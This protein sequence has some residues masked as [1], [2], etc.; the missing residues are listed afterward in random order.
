[1]TAAVF[2]LRQGRAILFLLIAAAAAGLLVARRL[3]KAVYPEVEFY[4]EQVVATLPGAPAATMIAGVTRP[5]EE[6]LAAIPGVE[7]IRS[8]TI[9][10]ATQ[11]SLFF[12]HG[13]DMPRVQAL[14]VARMAEIRGDLPPDVQ[15]VASRVTTS[16][17][18]ILSFNVEGPLPPER[19]YEL[20][21]YTLVPALSGLPHVGTI[22]VQ[23]SDIPEVQVLLDPERLSASQLTVGDVA[24]ALKSTNVVQAVA[25]ITDAHELKLGIVTGEVTTTAELSEAVVGGT[26]QQPIRVRDLGRVLDGV[27][28]RTR[29]I[30]V[31]G[32]PGVILN[33]SRRVGGDIFKVDR[34][35]RQRLAELEPSLPTG[36]R[37]VPVYEQA[38]FVTEGVNGVR[39][40]VL[41]GALF[42]VAVLALF[43][44]DLRATSIAAMSLP[45]ALGASLLVLGALGQSLNLMT[46]GGLAVAVGLVIDDAVVVIEAVHKNLEAGLAPRLAAERGTSELFWPVVGT[47]ATT[48][49][50]FL[51]LGLQ[52]GVSGAFFTAFSLA[53]AS[54]VLISLPVALLAMPAVAARFLRPLRKPSRGGRL[55]QRYVHALDRVLDHPWIP[56]GAAA[57]LLVLGTL[58]F[59]RVPT[60]FLP[61]AD[62]G[63]YVID[64]FPPVGA[65]L[66]EAD[67]L[68]SRIEGVVA[69]T[70]EV[71]AFARRLGA[72]LGPPTA[73]LASSGDISVRLATERERAIHEVLDEQRRELAVVVPGVRVEFI[74]VLADMLGDL[75]GAPEP[76]EVKIFGPDPEVLRRLAADA[77]ARIESVPGLVDFFNGDEG[78][79]PER[80]LRVDPIAAGSHGLTVEDVAVQLA[81]ANLGQVAT[82]LRRPDHLE[83]VRVR[84]D[85]NLRWGEGSEAVEGTP[86][87]SADAGVVPV[88]SVGRW[89]DSCP[90]ATQ[91]RDDHQ[92]IVHLTARLSG[93]SLG[94]AAKEVHARLRDWKLPAGYR[95]QL[96]GLLQPQKESFDRML[97][98][99]SVA[100]LAVTA[101]LL[102]QLR[103]VRRALAVLAAMPLAL[104]AGLITLWLTGTTL[105]VASMMGAVVLVG[106]VVKN[107]I[108]LLDH[109]LTAEERGVPSRDALLE[110]ASARLRPILMTTVATV[111]ALLPL[112]FGWSA[113]AALHRPLAMIVVGGLAFSTAA[114]LFVVPVLAGTRA[115]Q[116]KAPT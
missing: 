42:A 17:F 85:V 79:S 91:L 25:R 40:A 106:L 9:R 1:M 83:D 47:T 44:R 60:D 31:D 3:P 23:S 19:L 45:L 109:A 59:S 38:V 110:A 14:V 55:T 116:K 15:L 13:T 16:D 96:A 64:Y 90:P 75:E 72:E 115:R 76:I 57:A 74:Q 58:A 18:P 26:A 49:V 71:T 66:E 36:V 11:V 61:E 114:T 97:L 78:C 51:P 101:V 99:L 98:V 2:A 29:I 103:S 43:L 94:A 89:E 62:E 21:S 113:G 69:T 84:M 63:A 34:A 92:N 80:A 39:D 88:Q 8:R 81:G 105:N 4:R 27:Q 56:L 93:V 33:V 41:F 10:G 102:I 37:I 95:W 52:S 70:P 20:S 108:L 35:V 104:S 107:G 68:A 112:V 65:S 73:T 48:V 54:A 82:R 87:V 28:P 6:G 53:L 50:V 24:A 12:A 67:R 86:L 46:L 7:H 77:S 111:V 30:R 32:K 100:V 22:Q 5:L